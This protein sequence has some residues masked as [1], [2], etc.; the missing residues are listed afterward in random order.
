MYT[1]L[2]TMQ[3][4]EGGSMRCCRQADKMTADVGDKSC[5]VYYIAS[6]IIFIIPK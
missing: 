4:M 6:M 1:R 3:K 2:R 5:L